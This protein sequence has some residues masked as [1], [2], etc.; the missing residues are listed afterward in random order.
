MTCCP[1]SCDAGKFFSRFARR[2][3]KRF[4]KKGFEPSQKQLLEGIRKSGIDGVSLLE[5]GCGVGALHQTL[6]E[7]GAARA[8]GIDLAE[9]MVDEARR[10]AEERGLSARTEYRL[11][12]FLDL[13]DTVELAD[14]TILD[15]VI[16][17]Y[18][19]A[20]TMV[21]QS[22]AKT[23]RV[24][25][26]TIPRDRWF[27]RLGIAS[28]ATAMWLIRSHFRPYLHDARRIETWITD[29][30]FEKRYENQTAVWLTQVYLR[31]P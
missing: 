19:D 30:G 9:N 25:A 12:D 15:K 18:P 13:H 7:T 24:Y 3:S 20:E 10:L 22:L 6:L 11:G 21:K 8:V 16:C 1:H 23:V 17:C 29:Q 28:I 4:S 5:I 27:V 26:F 31:S 14:T 2:T